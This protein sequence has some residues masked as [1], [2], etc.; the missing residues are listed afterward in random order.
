[1]KIFFKIRIVFK[2]TQIFLMGQNGFLNMTELSANVAE[3]RVFERL[4]FFHTSNMIRSNFNK[5]YCIFLK[6]SKINGMSTSKFFGRHEFLLEGQNRTSC[7]KTEQSRPGPNKVPAKSICNPHGDGGDCGRNAG[8]GRGAAAAPGGAGGA[9]RRRRLGV[10]LSRPQ[11]PRPPPRPRPP[12]RPRPPQQL[13][14]AL[15]PRLRT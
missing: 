13:L 12:H 15:P 9:R 1:L 5:F 14:R 8:G 11:A 3:F 4:L 7:A 10:P 2:F 6:F